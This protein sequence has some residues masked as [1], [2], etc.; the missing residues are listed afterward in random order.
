MHRVLPWLL[1]TG[2]AID[3]VGKDEVGESRRCEAAQWWPHDFTAKEDDLLE[4]FNDARVM[5]GMCGETEHSPVDA[6]S[7]SPELRC[8]A[9]LH[10][11]D[12]ATT[13]N[14]S[15]TGSDGL[16]TVARVDATLY[17]NIPSAEL[18]AA[19]YARADE[20]IDAWL[21]SE[22]HCNEVFRGRTDEIGVGYG[23]NEDGG[24]AA[25]VVVVGELRNPE[26][27]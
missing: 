7:L 2:C 20:V 8:A 5:G 17:D 16:G 27:R 6:V 18:L 19:D 9:R 1:V 14:L 4:L 12:I 10:A 26:E 11:T 15:H 23:E 25:W 13:Q 22:E 3:V 21:A 24:A